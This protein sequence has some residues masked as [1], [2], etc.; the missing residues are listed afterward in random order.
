MVG[1]PA[2]LSPD[3]HERY[4]A[5]AG[6]VLY[7]VAGLVGLLYLVLA[8]LHPVMVG[9]RGGLIMSAAA[10]LTAVVL[11]AVALWARNR[12]V[13]P[14]G[15]AL[16]AAVILAMIFNSGLHLWITGEDWQ[17][18]NLML[19]VIGAGMA[20]LATR[21]NLVLTALCWVAWVIGMINIPGVNWPH[22]FI[23]MGMATL[24]GQLV[25]FG[26]RNNLDTA[27]NA[28]EI[29]VGLL[30]DAEELAESRQNLLA[31]ISHDVRTP[32]TGIVGM[33]DLLLQRPLDARTRELVVGVRHSAD[34][35]TTMLN[36]L[37]DLARVEA[38]KLEVHETDSDVCDMVSEVL[39]MVGPMAQAKRIPLIGA[40]SPDLHA[41]IRTDPSRFQQI[42]L[43]LVSNAVKFT[44]EGAVTVVSRPVSFNNQPWVQISVTDTGPGMS[45]Q[46]QAAAFD[47]FVQGGPAVHK[48]HGGSGLGLAIAQR[49][50][51]ALGGSLQLT[52][53]LGEGT[54]FRVL[55]PVGR[56]ERSHDDE[57]V[58]V[59]GQVVVT[60]HPVAVHAVGIAMER[61]GKT[62]V[63][64]C[65]GEPGTLHV[66]V[67]SDTSAPEAGQAVADGHRLLVLGPTVTVAAAP[68]AG[69]YLPMPWTMDRL[70]AALGAEVAHN[71]PTQV[72]AL[73]TGMRVLLAEDDTTNRN[74]IAEMLRRMG[75]AVTTVSDGAAAVEEVARDRFDVVLL[76]LNMPVMDGLDA[77]RVIR[78]RLA[79]MDTLAVVAL[80]ADPGWIDRSVLTAAGFNGY[81]IKP[82]TMAD[83]HIGITKVL[84]RLPEAAPPPV[85]QESEEQVSLETATLRQLADDL[86]DP[87][88]VRET[89]TVYLEEL[90]GRLVA[91]HQAQGSGSADE[92][93]SVAH[94]LK[95]ASGMLGAMRLSGLCARM[96]T[97]ADDATLIELTAE[98]E[99]VE[100]L[101]RSYLA[102]E[103]LT[104]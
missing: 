41:W 36:N 58:K 38:G 100:T 81:V 78:Q 65:T 35:L 4:D 88:L 56:L 21:W 91:L 19:V 94:S 93:R 72:L 8:A 71:V 66:R 28:V 96:E 83:L 77:V 54:T 49:L 6:K 1:I 99:Q 9:G 11:L 68:T 42:L 87:A 102:E 85:A 74:L 44:D 15:T 7:P 75:A 16:L 12:S 13:I 25:R 22:W 80:S 26:R 50:T 30:G 24:V 3:P 101:M 47:S 92:V 51:S 53:T 20:V 82:A 76:D 86:G 67:V 27:A 60:G 69:E 64:D 32:V 46:A 70:L 57:M 95:G 84:E 29:Q 33:V 45:P 97:Q 17:T 14:H 34:G 63:D 52:S 5:A 59:P 23:A 73:P 90:P 103:S 104:G 79:D 37:L 31:T 43:N 98:A 62:V 39:Q 10:G 2:E 48:E 61:M 89:L 40:A 18:T 55:L